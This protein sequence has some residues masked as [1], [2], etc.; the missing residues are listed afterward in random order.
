MEKNHRPNVLTDF[1]ITQ[2]PRPA[3]F[4][5]SVFA[6]M[7]FPEHGQE[8]AR[9]QCARAVCLDWRA[10][11][12]VAEESDAE[13]KGVLEID[14]QDLLI[15]LNFGRAYSHERLSALAAEGYTSG[16][17]LRNALL[18]DLEPATTSSIGKAKALTLKSVAIQ[19]RTL[20]GRWSKFKSVSHLWAAYRPGL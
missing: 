17:V 18:L 8:F 4:A 10:R 12:A 20:T 7:L 6:T 15:A 9:A 5:A 11:Y 14:R 2:V 13:G 16:T 1:E 3:S 19:E